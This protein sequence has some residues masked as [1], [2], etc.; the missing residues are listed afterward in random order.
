MIDVITNGRKS[1]LVVEK[2]SLKRCGGIGDILSGLTG[3]Y[4]YWGKKTF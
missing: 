3:L 2:S 1:F 4:S